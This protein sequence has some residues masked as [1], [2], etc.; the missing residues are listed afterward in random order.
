MRIAYSDIED[1]PTP[2]LPIEVVSRESS[3]RTSPLN[4]LLDSGA[5]VTIVPETELQEIDASPAGAIDLEGLWGAA[6]TVPM[7]HVDIWIGNQY[8]EHV[9]LV[10]GPDDETILG[11]DVINQLRLLLDGPALTLELLS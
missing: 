5:Q 10:G 7:Y 1:P 9:D 6:R 8:L 4:A 11:R 3:E 2:I